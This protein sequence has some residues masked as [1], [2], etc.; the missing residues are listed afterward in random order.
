[1]ELKVKIGY[2]ELWELIKQLPPEQLAKLKEE[3][4]LSTSPK[5]PSASFQEFLKRGPVMS[6][7]QHQRY[8][9]HRESFNAWIQD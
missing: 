2:E 7:E 1:M 9:E 8:L 4:Y 5:V 3:L 6:D